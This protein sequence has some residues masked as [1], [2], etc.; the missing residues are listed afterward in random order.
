MMNEGLLTVIICMQFLAFVDFLMSDMA[1]PHSLYRQHFPSDRF[2]SEKG[3][4][5]CKQKPLQ[6]CCSQA[7]SLVY[8]P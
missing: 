8:A 1:F 5:H 7:F 3:G 6:T 4:T 2:P